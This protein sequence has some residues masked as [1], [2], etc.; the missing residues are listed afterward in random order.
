VPIEQGRELAGLIAD[1]RFVPVDSENHM[2]L[3]D[4]PAWRQ[5]VD[6]IEKFL[7]QPRR[8]VDVRETLPLDELTP[9][10]RAVL[11][12]IAGGLDNGEIASLLG[13]SEKTVRNHI[14]R[15]FDKIG[16]EHRYQ[17]IV[18]ARDAGLGV[19]RLAAPH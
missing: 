17:A 3:A 12:G 13:L 16:V 8:R 15:V 10:E 14:T 5:I 1:S 9:R 6:E 19:N 4:E 18:R 11:E 2:P 7:S